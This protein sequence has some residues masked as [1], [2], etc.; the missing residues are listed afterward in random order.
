MNKMK[1]VFCYTIL[2]AAL[3]AGCKGKDN[4][5]PFI[6]SSQPEKGTA[7]FLATGGTG[8]AGS[9]GNGGYLDIRS[10]G[11]ITIKKSGT[12]DASFI[13]TEPTPSFGPAHVVISSGTT[14]T[15][16][17]DGDD[18]YLCAQS[19]GDGSI[20]IGNGDG[21]CDS[22]DTLVTGL[23]VE[24]G[25]TLVITDSDA[26]SGNWSGYGAL[27]LSN[28]LV[29]DG[30][31]NTDASSGLW[32]E[33][34]LIQVGTAGSLS[35]SAT[36]TDTGAK[37]MYLG[38]AYGITK[39]IINHG[40]IEAKGL[41]NGTGG[42]LYME[43][44]D[45]VANDGTIDLSAGSSVNG[46]GPMYPGWH[47]LEIYVDYGNF[48]SSGTVRMNGGNGNAGTGGDAG[49]ARIKTA[50]Y[51]NDRGLN[52]DIILSGTWEAMG[53]NGEAGNGGGKG[54]LYFETDGMGKIAV[55]GTIK[56]TGGYGKGVSASGGSPYGVEFYSSS[57]SVDVAAPP[58]IQFSGTFDLRGGDGDANGGNA[59]YLD[60]YSYGLNAASQGTNIE[61]VGFP[62]LYLDGGSGAVN[63]GV[64]GYV[65]ASAA[66]TISNSSSMI[67]TGGTGDTGGSTQ[68][69]ALGD[70]LSFQADH[71]TTTGGLLVN[72]GSGTT[73][74]GAGGNI[75]IN[76]TGSTTS[77][78]D[79]A[80]MSAAGGA[81]G[82]A[83]GTEGIITIDGSAI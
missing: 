44:E 77:T 37:E 72:G 18:G 60:A 42:Y 8:S 71:V 4:K 80:N 53:G 43:A 78:A 56:V 68:G 79:R 26:D 10:S 58:V 20:Y 83:N 38:Y 50:N 65:G 41:G 13:V 7:N 34:N 23:T 55:D 73:T 27:V 3:I 48:Y 35:T 75:T 49:Q 70:S 45:M 67:L 15:V 31:L 11:A 40:T 59:G 82:T 47:A 69:A 61:L 36:V 5:V 74:G 9:G 54:Y 25:A 39:K 28:D 76:S 32:I 14:T 30:T 12:V 64:G 22:G 63:G 33:A 29:V 19:L 51:G 16:L 21:I 24:P 46:G 66:T 81:G 1:V 62:I 2:A 17:V 52:G 6:P 57:G